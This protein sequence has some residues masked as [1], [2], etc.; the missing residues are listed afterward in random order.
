MELMKKLWIPEDQSL[1]EIIKED[2]LTGPTLS[3]PYSSQRFYINKYWS[4][5]V[6]GAVILQ[7]DY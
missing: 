6:L 2:I 7:V 1:M 4:K 3:I 5:D